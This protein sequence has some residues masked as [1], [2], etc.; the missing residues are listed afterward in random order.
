MSRTGE[1]GYYG[2][3]FKIVFE[4]TEKSGQRAASDETVIRSQFKYQEV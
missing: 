1:M 3:V 4:I 2:A